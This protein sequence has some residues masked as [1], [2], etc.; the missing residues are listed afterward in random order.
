MEGL[1]IH[2]LVLLIILAVVVGL[3]RLAQSAGVLPGWM[4]QAAMLI[5]GAIFLIALIYLLVPLM[6]SL[7]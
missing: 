4:G 2:L 6:H 1:L 7:P 5:V 3:I